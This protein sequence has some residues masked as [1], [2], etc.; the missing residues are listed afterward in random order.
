MN[1]FASIFKKLHHKI[2][3]Y[4]LSWWAY[5]SHNKK[6]FM[7]NRRNNSSDNI[8]LMELNALHS[9]HIAYAYLSNE[10]SD[11]FRAQIK[12]YRPYAFNSW[13]SAAFFYLKALLK[14]E[15]FGVY[16]SFGA[17]EFFAPQL[18][19]A[20]RKRAKSLSAQALST[21]TTKRCVENLCVEGIWIGDLLYDSFLQQKRVPTIDIN[22]TYFREFLSETMELFVFWDDYFKL[23]NVVAINVSHCVYNVAIPLRIAIKKG[24]P[25]FQANATHIYR[26]TNEQN[27]AYNDFKEF[28]NKFLELP[29]GIQKRGK[30]I[31]RERIERRFNGEVGVDMSYSTKSAYGDIFDRRLMRK[32]EN[33]K[34]LVAAHCFFDSPHSYGV[35]LFP[36]FYDWFE[37]LGEKSN[38]TDYD[39]YVKTHP[40]YLPETKI[41]IENFIRK[42][43]KFTLL[44]PEASH[45][46]LIEEGIDVALTC[47]GTIGFEYA[48]LGIPVINA[49]QCNPH[50]AY[51]FNIHPENVS[52]YSSWIDNIG[53]ISWDIDRDKVHEYYFM[54]FIYN[55]ENIFF[56]NYQEVITELGGYKGQFS[57]YV[58]KKWL[59]QWSEERHH[60]IKGAIRNF[61]A[62]GDY[63]MEAKHTPNKKF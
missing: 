46:Q 53:G 4:I 62:S 58:Y 6:K 50:I 17:N 34:V 43:K 56:K 42:Y 12:A 55:T 63:R 11:M 21:I 45:H 35:N 28:P 16:Y 14:L 24:V 10:L 8:V 33:K 60:E 5:C 48:A 26:L 30:A 20:Q 39:W 13:Y 47:Y 59:D 61:I 29:S 49:S 37:F 18:T 9:A 2:C 32:S 15:E 19:S 44:P 38:E 41:I 54:K 25:A 36:D 57:P 27:R 1:I 7:A 40:D 51:S 23:R 22:S 31:A 3:T 52:S